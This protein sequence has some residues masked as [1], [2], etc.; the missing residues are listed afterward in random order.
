VTVG[1]YGQL[2]IGDS[3]PNDGDHYTGVDPETAHAPPNPAD[4]PQ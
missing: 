2:T 3:R 4:S 1:A